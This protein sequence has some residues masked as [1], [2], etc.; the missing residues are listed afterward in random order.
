MDLPEAPREWPDPYVLMKRFYY[1]VRS[2]FVASRTV[3][4]YPIRIR[5]NVFPG[6]KATPTTPYV[7]EVMGWWVHAGIGK[8]PAE[9]VEELGRQL[10]TFS[11]HRPMPRP[12]T[13]VPLRA[14]PM[15]RIGRH[16]EIVAEL[17]NFL[18]DTDLYLFTDQTALCH[19][20]DA[21]ELAENLSRYYGIT[22]PDP[23]SA[24]LVDIVDM[25]A[26][27]RGLT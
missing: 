25:I 13:R 3:R 26:Q 7:A 23:E 14:A 1:W 9:A 20:G 4:D 18:L 19:F 12:G 27:R 6:E 15:E 24:L 21:H 2:F 17:A 8:T 5:R 22:I 16:P 10:E 11:Q